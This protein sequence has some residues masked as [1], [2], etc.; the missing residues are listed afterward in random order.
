LEKLKKHGHTVIL[1]DFG[2]GYSSLSYLRYLP[3]KKIKI[4]KIFVNNLDEYSTLVLSSI[5]DL[6]QKL[7][8]ETVVEGIETESQFQLIKKFKVNYYQGF[9]DSTPQPIASFFSERKN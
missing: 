5:I 4:D 1:D 7:S 8:A 6:C 3:I 2:T 9:L